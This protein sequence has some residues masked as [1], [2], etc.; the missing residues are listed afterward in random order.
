MTLVDQ[1]AGDGPAGDGPAGSDADVGLIAAGA[2][3]MVTLAL[4]MG[5]L[6]WAVARAPQPERLTFVIPAGTDDRITMLEPVDVIP[7]EIR[8]RQ[9]GEIT[10]VNADDVAFQFGTLSVAAGQTITKRF[11]ETGTFRNTCRLTPGQEVV[12]TVV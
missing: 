10:L 7:S 5:L 4:G 9:G 12:I 1:P 6:L 8:I 11:T 2:L 3:L